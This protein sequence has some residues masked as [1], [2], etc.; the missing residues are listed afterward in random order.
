MPR[1]RLATIRYQALDKCFSDR[2]RYYFAEDLLAA[3]N[4][5]LDANGAPAISRRTLFNDINDMQYNN[6]W[7]FLFEEPARINGRRYYR[8]ADPNYSIWRRDLNEHQLSQ[9]KSMLLMLQQFRGLPQFERIEEMMQQLEEH[10]H[11][12]LEDTQDIIAFDTNNYVDGLQHLSPLFEAI[13]NKQALKI[14]YRPFNKSPYAT[15]V[16]PYYIKQYNGRWFMFG[17]TTN[18]VYQNISNLALDR[19]QEIEH[20]TET[21]IPNTTINFEEYFE[22][23]IGVTKSANDIPVK[24]LL[25]FS[26]H[27][28][29]Y[30]LSKPM[31]ESQRNNRAD[32]GI[33][34]L[35]LVPNK[36]FYQRLLSFGSDVEVLEPQ[37]VREEMTK[38]AQ[39]LYELYK[40]R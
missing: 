29:P 2:T 31:H 36:E 24:I 1:T 9:L 20:T 11:F 39:K 5:E 4:R 19:I 12:E 21:Y 13:I 38:N 35:E 22:D 40:K 26:A 8:Y 3:I 6:G 14:T 30:V 18:G 37:F 28:L 7:D 33:I 27:R 10:Y 15:I 17:L 32:E 34:E 25:R 16:H 23:I